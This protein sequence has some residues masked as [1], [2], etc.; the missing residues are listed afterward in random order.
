MLRT[1]LGRCL[2]GVVAVM[3]SGLMLLPATAQTEIIASGTFEGRGGHETSGGVTILQTD[4][5]VT[6]MLEG[7]FSFDGAPRSQ[8]GVRQQWIRCIDAVHPTRIQQR[9]PGLRS[10]RSDRSGELQRTLVVVRTV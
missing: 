4:A 10:F 5:G 6:V 2:A 8:A 9:G 3:G 1:V 7:D